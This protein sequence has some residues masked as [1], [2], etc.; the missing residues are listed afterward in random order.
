MPSHSH[1]IINLVDN[2]TADNDIK[3]SLQRAVMLVIPP[4]ELAD[5]DVSSVQCRTTRVA[6]LLAP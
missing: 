3:R 1:S 4:R 5:A 2:L 6:R